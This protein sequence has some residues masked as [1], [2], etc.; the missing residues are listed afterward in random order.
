MI[1]PAKYRVR[2][3]IYDNVNTTPENPEVMADE[4]LYGDEELSMVARNA[5][6]NLRR[7]I[8]TDT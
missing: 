8:E 4:P 6:R 3:V 5:Y 2:I 7:H 1:D